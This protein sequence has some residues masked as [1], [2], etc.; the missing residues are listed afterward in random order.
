MPEIKRRSKIQLC[1]SRSNFL[2]REH[3]TT[4]V[5]GKRHKKR[6]RVLKSKQEK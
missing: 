6:F 5:I 2:S 1:Y 4:Y 3:R